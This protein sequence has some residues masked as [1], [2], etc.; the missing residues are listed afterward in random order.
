M[1]PLLFLQL[2]QAGG[3]VLRVERVAQ[4]VQVL[5]LELVLGLVLVLVLVLEGE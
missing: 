5:V 1:L 2:Q 4:E 3:G